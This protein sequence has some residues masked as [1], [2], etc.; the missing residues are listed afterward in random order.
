[1]VNY[2]KNR[3]FTPELIDGKS[4]NKGGTLKLVRGFTLM[5]MLIVI[6]LVG[7][8]ASVALFMDVNSYRGDAFRGE[9]N[10]L[11]LALQT[12]RAD[13]LNNI[14]QSKHGVAIHP[15]GYD[16]YVIFQ[17]NS[18]AT[19]NLAFDESIKANYSVTFGA[20]PTEIIFDQL[21]G[22]ANYD[23]DVTMTDS[24]RNMTAVI[25]INHEGKI[26]W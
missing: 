22:D 4:L 9:V 21:S 2:E 26:S 7:V 19:R 13:A 12:S 14:N 1:M 10:A 6:G 17:G 8:L 5:E 16:G 23:G 15:G 18:Y 20:T 24:Q 11:G 3:G 25:T